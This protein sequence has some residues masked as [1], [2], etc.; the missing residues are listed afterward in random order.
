MII[1][2]ALFVS[3]RPRYQ[4]EFESSLLLSGSRM[5]F[6][7]SLNLFLQSEEEGKDVVSYHVPLSL[8]QLYSKFKWKYEDFLVMAAIAINAV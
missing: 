7:K 6:T 2:F 3:S 1:Q 5:S 4:V 8:R